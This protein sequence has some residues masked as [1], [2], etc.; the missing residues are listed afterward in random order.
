[1]VRIVP[2]LSVEVAPNIC[3]WFTPTEALVGA[4]VTF[5]TGSVEDEEVEVVFPPPHPASVTASST[6]SRDEPFLVI[7]K[8]SMCP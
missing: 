7:R 6:Q 3:V 4:R 2:L 5:D 8:D 1:M